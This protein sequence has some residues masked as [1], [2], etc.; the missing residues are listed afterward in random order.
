MKIFICFIFLSGLLKGCDQP[1]VEQEITQA[2]LVQ[3]IAEI[4]ALI[5]KGSC[6]SDGECKF[7]AYGSKACGGP[8][9]YFVYSSNVDEEKLMGLVEKHTRSEALYNQ[10]K[11]IMS[12]CSIVPEPQAIKCQNGNC[13]EVQP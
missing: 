12:D 8:Q 11:G 7:I 4:E 10:Q 1:A 3:Q 2:Q 9:G 6:T 13:I 5:E